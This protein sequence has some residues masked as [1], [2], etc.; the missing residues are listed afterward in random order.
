MD[1]ID[2]SAPP[3]PLLEVHGLTVEF[4]TRRGVV[5]AV[6]DVSFSV[7]PG[8]R[9][10]IVGESGSGK[11][12]ACLAIGGFLPPYA[13]VTAESM[14][15]DE[16]DL[17]A[18]K[19]SRIPLGTPHLGLVFQDAMTSLDPVWTVGSQLLAALKGKSLRAGVKES[20]GEALAEARD[21]LHRVGL[22]DTERVMKARPDALSGGMRQRVMIALALCGGPELLIAD[23]PTSALDASTSHEVMD[24]MVEMT[25]TLGAALII[26]SHDL[27]LCQEYTSR[28][29][30]MYGGKAVE[31]APSIDLDTTAR[32]P[33]TSALL[34]CVPT[35]AKR[36]VDLLPIIPVNVP[37]ESA[38]VHGQC[39]FRDR[40]EFAV[41]ACA[42]APPLV[43]VADRHEA[44]CWVT[45]GPTDADSRIPETV[46]SH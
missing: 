38:S 17:L 20:K 34:G 24:L 11:S 42:V 1:S 14:R 8:E 26:V 19:T 31:Q 30:V 46:G 25:E 40:C 29:V 16:V 32:H 2:T 41:A 6:D 33:Y 45:A 35:L 23:E 28:M 27:K 36:N 15:L 44:A 43:D 10:A 7:Q 21:W 9:L 13:E 12:T 3:E 18:R 5:R 39:V 22:T 4:R 37:R